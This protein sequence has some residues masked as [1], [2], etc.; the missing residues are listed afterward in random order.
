MRSYSPLLIK[1]GVITLEN[2]FSKAMSS[3]I[4]LSI[5]KSPQGRPAGKSSRWLRKSS[6]A[7]PTHGGSGSC[8]PQAG[9]RVCGCSISLGVPSFSANDW[10]LHCPSVLLRSKD[11]G[12]LRKAGCKP[13]P[14]LERGGGDQRASDRVVGIR[15]G[16]LHPA[17]PGRQL[18][19]R[20]PERPAAEPAAGR[21]VRIVGNRGAA[22]QQLQTRVENRALTCVENVVQLEL[23]IASCSVI[24]RQSV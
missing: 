6:T 3:S 4:S 19:N 5:F 11:T 24:V 23:V 9:H 7:T 14:R 12:V 10:P 20:R 13:D 16:G 2:L 17:Y 21:V 18:E 15:G 8:S 22:L 1:Q